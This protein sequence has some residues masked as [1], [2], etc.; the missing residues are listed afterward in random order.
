MHHLPRRG[1]HG[2]GTRPS[3]KVAAA[4]S[5]L[6]ALVVGFCVT[7]I[8]PARAADPGVAPVTDYANYPD[9]LGIV[10]AGCNGGNALTGVDFAVGGVHHA[11]LGDFTLHAGDVITMT[12]TGFGSGCEQQ[13]ISLSAKR[14]FQNTFD[15]NDDQQLV[16]PF[17]YCGPGGTSCADA[18]NTLTLTV[19]PVNV[20]CNFQID[21]ALGPPLADVGPHGSY[22]SNSLR[23][24]NGTN[25]LISANNGGES[26]C[27]LPPE[28]TTAVSCAAGGLS[29][30]VVNPDNLDAITVSITKDG[31]PVVTDQPVAAAGGTFDTVVPLADHTPSHVVITADVDGTPTSLFDD[32]V[33]LDCTH[34]AATVAPRCAAGGSGAVVTLTN[35]GAELPVVF[36]I[37]HGDQLVRVAP[38]ATETVVLPIGEDDSMHVTVTAEGQSTPLFDGDVTVNC[39]QPSAAIAL[40]CTTGATL[41]LGNAGAL[42]TTLTVTKNGTQI[43]SVDVPAGG[44]VT[45]DYPLQEDEVATFAVTGAGFDSGPLAATHDCTQVQ[46]AEQTR[47]ASIPRTGAD[48]EPMLL[49]AGLLLAFGGTLVAT[50]RGL[51]FAAGRRRR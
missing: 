50:G 7:S 29:V 2:A 3:T 40:S 51:V 8:S 39:V 28:A 21:A 46:G 43:D 13:G 4:L 17:A 9:G 1:R 15:I 31:K 36:D 37:N 16:Q 26:H 47:A 5:L 14:A 18:G 27:N 38:N 48:I 20:A 11:Q 24:D 19:P 22:Y 32:T 44:T 25:M 42:P 34:P 41:T 49:L 6:L 12:W 35:E 10:V 30:H 45:R 33:T 23:G